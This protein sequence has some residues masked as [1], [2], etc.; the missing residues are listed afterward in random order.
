MVTPAP[1]NLFDTNGEE[2]LVNESDAERFYLVVAKLLFIGKRG[3]PDIESV[4][5]YLCTR[6][7]CTTNGDMKKLHRLICSIKSTLNDTRVIG[8]DS[9]KVLHTWIDASYAVHQDMKGQTGGEILLGTGL[10]HGQSSKQKINAKSSTE[11][12]L[13]GVSEYL[14]FHVW[15]VNF[16]EKQG[17]NLDRKILY[18][19]KLSAMGFKKTDETHAQGTLDMLI[20]VIFL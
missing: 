4:V 1:K 10:I 11:S 12:D 3:R 5:A 17:Y 7:L 18:Q 2:D 19:D 13:I 20:Y 6:V 8:A 9:L 14:P 15:T 16:L